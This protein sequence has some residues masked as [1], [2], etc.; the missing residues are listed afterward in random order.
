MDMIE[1]MDTLD[2]DSMYLLF[3]MAFFHE[4]GANLW[5]PSKVNANFKRVLSV[6]ISFFKGFIGAG[7][8]LSGKALIPLG[9]KENKQLNDEMSTYRHLAFLVV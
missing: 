6:F 3:V 7:G 9:R 4:E 1:L 8:P 2:V 5:V